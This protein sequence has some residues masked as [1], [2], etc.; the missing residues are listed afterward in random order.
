MLHI[1]GVDV[2]ASHEALR[3]TASKA[4][5]RR[6]GCHRY[7]SWYR[8]TWRLFLC[9][10]CLRFFKNHA[11]VASGHNSFELLFGSNRSRILPN[12]SRL[13]L[14]GYIFLMRL[15]SIFDVDRNLKNFLANSE[16]FD[17]VSF[18]G[19]NKNCH[20]VTQVF[21]THRII[22]ILLWRILFKN[23]KI[24][25]YIKFGTNNALIE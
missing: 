1:G 2:A 9:K 17:G 19:Y 14:H 3:Q 18:Y 5:I 25:R 20:I 24:H 12:R 16:K 21:A 7:G 11:P 6:T 8:R 15:L 23:H 13:R 10:V 22:M 4:H